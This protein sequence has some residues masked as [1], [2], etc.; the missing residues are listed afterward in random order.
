MKTNILNIFTSVLILL[1]SSTFAV[2][3]ENW[4]TGLINTKNAQ[5][6]CKIDKDDKSLSIS[7][8]VNDDRVS[9]PFLMNEGETVRVYINSEKDLTAIILNAFG[10]ERLINL[11]KQGESIGILFTLDEV[12]HP[13][14]L[15]FTLKANSS[16][17][18]E[19]I[20]YIDD[21]I[22]KKVSFNVIR[23]KPCKSPHTN[24]FYHRISLEEVLSGK[25]K[26]LKKIEEEGSKFK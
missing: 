1:S 21:Q 24:M 10:K 3:Q 23:D 4:S 18:P 12:G 7:K 6:N 13:I 2:A 15:T 11:F 9:L 5:F 22:R 26:R 25:I 19:E 16:I 20:F 8:V 17:K 14:Q